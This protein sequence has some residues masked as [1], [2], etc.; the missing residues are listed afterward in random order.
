MVDKVANPEFLLLKSPE[1]E[2]IKI[3]EWNITCTKRNILN[4]EELDVLNSELKM[5]SLPEMI[6]GNNYLKLEH[7]SGI[8]LSFTALGALKEVQHKAPSQAKVHYSH[9][10]ISSKTGST[11][12]TVTS[13]E[14]FKVYEY[15]WTFTTAYKGTLQNTTPVKTDE[16]IDIEKLKKP[17]PILYFNELHLFED[18]LADNGIALSSVKMRVMP[19]CF[20]ILLRFWLRI[21]NVLFRVFDTRIFHEFGKSYLIRECQ[22]RE[23]TWKDIAMMFPNDPT[24]FNDANLITPL[25]TMRDSFIEKIPLSSE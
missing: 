20:F 4:S 25:V 8:S 11:D 21:D 24:K 10:W 17:D 7:N 18:E 13:P 5:K 1:H 9:N 12:A 14:A 22:A 6:F 3:G 2:G 15:D 23:S 16:K 19:S